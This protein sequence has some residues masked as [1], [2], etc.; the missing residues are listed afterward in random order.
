MVQAPEGLNLK[1]KGIRKSMQMSLHDC[2]KVLG[3]STNRYLAFEQGEESLSLPEL[4]I[5]AF[6]FGIPVMEC[7]ED[8]IN[9]SLRF[10]L[11]KDEKRTAYIHLREKWI[12]SRLIMEMEEN[13]SDLADLSEELNIPQEK[14]NGYRNGEL[15]IPL[16]HLQVICTHFQLPLDDLFPALEL[17]ELDDRGTIKQ[18][19]GQWNPEFPQGDSASGGSEA[20][21]NQLLAALK[22]IPEEDQ[23]QV[24]KALLKKLRSI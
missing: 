11:L 14:L 18:A 9:S 23:A 8:Q 24:A 21:Y 7:L 12:R 5:L 2:A 13:E 20:L 6:Y 22:E 16:N 15:P 19:A 17:T 10:S 4:E 3:T 1:I